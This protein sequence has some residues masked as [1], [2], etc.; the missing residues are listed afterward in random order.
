MFD[1]EFSQISMYFNRRKQSPNT[2]DTHRKCYLVF[3]L[4]LKKFFQ[5]TAIHQKYS[6]LKTLSATYLDQRE[7]TRINTGSKT[8]TIHTFLL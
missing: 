7:N 5:E 6:I 8:G 1:V 3:H 4:E 2:T